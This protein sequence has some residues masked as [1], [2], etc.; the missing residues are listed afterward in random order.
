[1][2]FLWTEHHRKLLNMPV[3]EQ[4]EV[5]FEWMNH[6]ALHYELQQWQEAIPNLGCAF[7]LSCQSL[8]CEAANHNPQERKNIA[9]QL[10]LSS[11]YL[12]NAYQHYKDYDKAQFVLAK[13]LRVLH[14][15]GVA[16]LSDSVDWAQECTQTL[17]HQECHEDYFERYLNLPFT[18]CQ[19][20]VFG[21][22]LH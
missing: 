9:T 12:A 19:Q 6:A 13:A 7:D 20:R 18:C 22:H 4:A 11:I 15:S 16:G 21:G 1:M 8:L 5:W 17:L 10:T 3:S 14:L 2:L